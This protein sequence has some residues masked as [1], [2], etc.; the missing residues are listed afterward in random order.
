MTM[1]GNRPSRTDALIDAGLLS[2]IRLSP[3]AVVSPSPF[4]G[5][6]TVTASGRGLSCET[7]L[8]FRTPTVSA[9][10]AELP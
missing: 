10:R 1:S 9:D 5:Y 3:L 8:I 4:A 7:T 2:K 6:Q